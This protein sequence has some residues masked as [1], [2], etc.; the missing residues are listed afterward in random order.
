MFSLSTLE[1]IVRI[2]PDL[3]GTSLNKAAINILKSKYE[4]RVKPEMGNIIHKYPNFEDRI[5]FDFEIGPLNLA[6]TK[7]FIEYRLTRVGA[8]DQTWFSPKSIE[9]IY[10]NTHSIRWGN[11]K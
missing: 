11:Q 9:K 7:G 2:P 8:E 4:T 1:D 10:K 5:S 3:F 6:D